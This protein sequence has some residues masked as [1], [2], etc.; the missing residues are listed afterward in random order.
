M[1]GRV[2][3]ALIALAMLI[4]PLAA[5]AA[6][7][8]IIRA[9]I[10]LTRIDSPSISPDGR[11]A[12][13][14]QFR[15]SIDRNDYTADWMIAPI[16]GTAPARRL[17][18]AGEI[19]WLN[20]YPLPNPPVW[21]AGSDMVLFRKVA[22]GEVQVWSAD[23]E[24]ISVRQ[25]T[26]ETGNVR[27]LQ[28]IRGGQAVLLALG[29]DRRRVAEAEQAEYENGT[30]IDASVDP[31]RPL[32]HGD[33]IDGRWASGRLRGFWFEQGG[34][35]PREKPVLRVLDPATAALRDA[36]GEEMALYAPAAKAFDRLGDWFVNVRETSGDAR[37]AALVLARGGETRLVVAD[38]AG[39][40]RARCIDQACASGPVR[41]VRWMG[42][43][44]TILFET[45]D[46][47]GAS[48]LMRWDTRS[49]AVSRLASGLGYLNGG[50]D[51]YGC[52]ASAAQVLCVEADANSPP[53]VVAIS[54]RNGQVTRL[55][56]PNTALRRVD[57]AFERIEWSDP[58]GRLF[59]GFLA[60]PKAANE[61]VPLFV[62][63]YACGGYL[64]GGLG[65]EY[66]LRAMAASR[67]AA[68]CVNRYPAAPGVGGNV[69]AYRTAASGIAAIVS[70]LAREGRIDPEK[71]GAG[72]VSFGGEVA[73]WLAMHTKLLRA[74][75]VANVM[76]TPTYYWLNAVKGREVPQV[77]K[78]GWGL[79]P[80]DPTSKAWREVSPAMN[81]DR[82]S[83][84]FLMQIPEQEYR[85]NVELLARLQ[86]AG[87]EAELWVFPKEMHIKWQPAHQF[88]ANRRNLAWFLCRIGNVCPPDAKPVVPDVTGQ[89]SAQT[90]G[91]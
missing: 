18:D 41:A 59:T 23:P 28:A 24:G 25:V 3:C 61:P 26:R 49:G 22:K 19:E 47:Q 67:I 1:V 29:P 53:Q 14:R 35:L 15:A 34:I 4:P 36:S 48:I 30:Q 62:T 13:W 11:W 85:P 52:A 45:R 90:S 27:D 73:T 42:T 50:D 8:A 69:E 70:K 80:P 74:V 44:D 31:Q 55:S 51:G 16:D 9:E 20:G 60:L 17:A 7:E 87:K 78:Q 84:A 64:R 21:N 82:I 65:D 63:Y 56:D 57:P 43:D 81:V 32:H 71:V 66:P 88:A 77:L 46:P 86:A 5:H 38:P 68:L 89:A 54:V 75:S 79:G 72:G 83:V 76:V 2:L 58:E 10:E 40:E 6:G 12:L 33:R 91:K 39:R 37:G